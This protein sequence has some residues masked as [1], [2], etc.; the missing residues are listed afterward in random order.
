MRSSVES[1]RY[2][3]CRQDPACTDLTFVI[4][5]VKALERNEASDIIK[6]PERC[7]GLFQK[8]THKLELRELKERIKN[9]YECWTKEGK[10]SL[11]FFQERISAIAL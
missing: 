8:L 9:A 3:Q 6:D 5:I 2:E 10:C 7:K 11:T 1:V 4:N